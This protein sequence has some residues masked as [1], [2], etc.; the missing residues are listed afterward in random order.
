MAAT[1]S[2]LLKRAG[3]AS[4]SRLGTPIMGTRKACAMALAVAMPTRS[5]VKSPGPRSTATTEI[6]RSSTR[7]CWQA[8][9]IAGARDS[10]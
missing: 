6:S 7:A 1:I 10:A 2:R 8:N 4:R 5:P 3:K 9:S